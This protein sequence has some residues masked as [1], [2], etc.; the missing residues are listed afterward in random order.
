MLSTKGM[1]PSSGFIA[2]YALLQ[3]C[4][5]VSVYGFGRQAPEAGGRDPVFRYYEHSK[6][7]PTPKDIALT[8]MDVEVAA[9]RAMQRESRLVLCLGG[10]VQVDLA[11]TPD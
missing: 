5:H 8:A 2:V 4:T 3:T 11:L 6:P 1:L 10:A 7:P 9:L